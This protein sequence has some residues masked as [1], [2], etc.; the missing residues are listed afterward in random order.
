MLYD[1]CDYLMFCYFIIWLFF[2]HLNE[3]GEK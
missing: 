2:H 1:V 3:L